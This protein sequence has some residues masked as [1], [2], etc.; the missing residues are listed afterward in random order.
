MN[1]ESGK[2]KPGLLLCQK[3]GGEGK[4]KNVYLS[5][6]LVVVCKNC[7][8]EGPMASYRNKVVRLWNEVR[9]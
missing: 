6:L 7:G 4:I 3:C 5:P 8:N 2:Q 9:V 1:K